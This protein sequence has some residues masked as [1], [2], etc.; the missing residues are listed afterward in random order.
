MRSG[1]LDESERTGARA[2]L[3]RVHGWVSRHWLV[4]PDWTGAM[5]GVALLSLVVWL[6]RAIALAIPGAPVV[7]AR[8]VA[9]DLVVAALVGVVV[10][11]VATLVARVVRRRPP[12]PFLAVLLAAGVLVG[13]MGPGI[14]LAGW[15]WISLLTLATGAAL[16]GLVGRVV[17]SRRTVSSGPGRLGWV[18][19]GVVTVAAISTGAWLALPG[20]TPPGPPPDRTGTAE[21]DPSSAG[22]F[23]V[24]EFT[25]GSGR[26]TLA[27]YGS[28]VDVVTDTVDASVALPE[29]HQGDTRSSVW[30]F[31]ASALPLNAT[32]WHP[33]GSGEFPLVLLLHGNAQH[34]DSEL[35]LAYLAEHLASRGYVVASIDQSFLNT[36]LLDRAGG[37]PHGDQVRGWLV[38]QHLAQWSR[39]V[40]SGDGPITRVSLDEVSL[41]GHSRGGEAVA[42]AAAGDLTNAARPA[43]LAP[44]ELEGVGI[45]GV[46]ALAPSDG[47]I[48]DGPPLTLSGVDYLT[49]AGSHDADV[50]TFAGS[51]QFQRV[52]AGPDGLKAAVLL[53]RGN[54]TQFNELWGRHDAGAGLATRMLDTGVLITPEQQRDATSALV[55]AFLD[56]SIRDDVTARDLF[57]EPLPDVSWLPPAD[58]RVASAVGGITPV[59]LEEITVTGA[60]REI[61]DLP[62]R[63]GPTDNDVL[64]VHGAGG[65]VE[66]EVPADEATPESTIML[67]V[68]DAAPAGGR[69]EPVRLRVGTAGTDDACAAVLIPP[70]LDGRLGKPGLPVPLPDS[71]P[72]LE[73][74]RLP[75]AC[76][77]ESAAGP[78]SLQ[79][80]RLVVT[81]SGQPGVYL[82]NVRIT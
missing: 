35:G 21:V 5:L 56:A 77:A 73:T 36:G 58:V 63:T 15:A 31:D 66:I 43:G 13:T 9:A 16:G 49:I 57:T 82:D 17:G 60:T 76:L 33:D 14:S 68:A 24:R 59:P 64:R 28:D 27:R 50:A 74:V 19:T 55:T 80:V 67:D 3:A 30:G 48:V 47:L 2:Q 10:L 72:F 18:L 8:I 51:R 38:R 42:I 40:E 23:T 69:Q 20:G 75:L 61:V 53:H 41:L 6:G 46:I 81:G 65:E 62:S 22:A 70:T 25:Y 11:L 71:E 4:G 12:A 39:W 26:S 44:V 34:G 7:S 1:S 29:W 79:S 78:A 32:V 45:S 37:L 52:D 54:H